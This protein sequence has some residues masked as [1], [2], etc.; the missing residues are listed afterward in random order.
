[1]ARWGKRRWQIEGFFKTSKHRFGLHRFEQGTRTGVYRWLALSLLAF[2][3]AHGAH[4]AY[5]TA[6]EL[7]SCQDSCRL[8]SSGL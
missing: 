6:A 1:M 5:F 3:L 7:G 8:L 2:V 4:L